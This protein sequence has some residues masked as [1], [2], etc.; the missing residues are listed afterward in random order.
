MDLESKEKLKNFIIQNQ[1]FLSYLQLRNLVL[2]FSDI[3][4][5]EPLDIEFKEYVSENSE[6]LENLS[7]NNL[8]IIRE[9]AS[10]D[11][12]LKI[13]KIISNRIR[14]GHHLCEGSRFEWHNFMTY[15]I[16]QYVFGDLNSEFKFTETIPNKL[17][18]LKETDPEVYNYLMQAQTYTT[19]DNFLDYYEKGV[20]TK[21][22]FEFLQNLTSENSNIIET[23]NYGICEDDIISMHPEFIKRISKYLDESYKLIIIHNNNPELFQLLKNKINEWE[24]TLSYREIVNLEAMV[25]NAC[26]RYGYELKDLGEQDIDKVLDFCV[27]RRN[28][29][30]LKI[31]YSENYMQDCDNYYNQMFEKNLNSYRSTTFESLKN[32]YWEGMLDNYCRRFLGMPLGKCQEFYTKKLDKLDFSEINNSELLEYIMELKT[33]IELEPK[34]EESVNFL[35]QKVKS[36]PKKF[37]PIFSYRA[38]DLINIEL[39][40]SFEPS[41]ESTMQKLLQ[42]PE[43]EIITYNGQTIRKVNVKGDFSLIIRSTDSGFCEDKTLIDSSVKKTEEQNPDPSTC[44]KAGCFVTQDY[45]GVAPLGAN[46]VY[47]VFIK[48]T[49]DNVG[50]IGI[51]DINSHA[52][53]YGVSSANGRTM[54]FKNTT[55]NCRG[56]YAEAGVIDRSPDAIAIF[57]DQTEEQKE[58]AYKTA[59]EYGID[60]LYFDKDKIVESQIKKLDSLIQKFSK[61]GDLEILKKLVSTYETNIAG[62]LLNRDL[63]EP[64]NSCTKSI[65]NSKYMPIFEERENQIYSVIAQYCNT[66][67]G[68]PDEES[69]ITTV[70]RILIDEMEKYSSL[71]QVKE[72]SSVKMKF[73]A[74]EI[75]EI[76]DKKFKIEEKLDL[77]SLHHNKY[78]PSVIDLQSIVIPA[79]NRDLIG[80][81]DVEKTKK[82]VE[83]QI[84]KDVMDK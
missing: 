1:D 60:I 45:T 21:E 5:I 23:I 83:P 36:N 31:P 46:G 16:H 35:D 78:L 50:E 40:H 80:T 30:D 53:D 2:R 77:D 28:E 57:S 9:S 75:I 29:R 6:I 14:S 39:V 33:I 13:D 19:I 67:K 12:K 72:L 48:N 44:L 42:E 73:R 62:W 25:L 82:M 49:S 7:I 81:S 76:I 10:K 32:G 64:D 51:Y 47:M 66:Q 11:E 26:S 70:K 20:I 38:N 84:G 22:K 52:R 37:Q 3:P 18:E 61:T 79:I 8:L 34:T 55:D 41:F 69:N 54:S 65:N 58:L 68:L 59:L 24:S 43:S 17:E 71:G 63:T 15:E 27:R 74:E 4:G 56:P